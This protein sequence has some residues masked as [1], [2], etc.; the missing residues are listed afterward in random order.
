MNM[1]RRALTSPIEVRASE[2]SR[3]ISGYAA[4]FNVA[5]DIGG[6]FREQVAPGAFAKAIKGGD[7]RALF[8]HRSGAVLGRTKSGTLRMKEDERGLA[9]EIDLPDTQVARDLVASM[10]R[11]DIDGM[12]FGFNVTRQVWDETTDPPLRTIQEV[13]LHE[14]SVVT[15]PAY[16]ETE[17]ALRSLNESRGEKELKERN[18]QQAKARIAAR[19]AASEQKFRGIK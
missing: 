1:E 19:R 2:G 4:V 3:T 18:A 10:E 11:G 7:V 9:V 16:E 14:V 8:D 13:E 12:S 17:A 15:F 5:A 6:F